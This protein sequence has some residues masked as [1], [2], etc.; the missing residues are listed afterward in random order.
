MYTP[1]VCK[2]IFYCHCCY[3][4]FPTNSIRISYFTGLF[5]FSPHKMFLSI[6][7]LDQCTLEL[8]SGTQCWC[9]NSPGAFRIYDSLLLWRRPTVI[10]LGSQFV[11]RAS[12][13]NILDWKMHPREKANWNTLRHENCA[14]QNQPLNTF[15]TV[16]Y[17]LLSIQ[18][19]KTKKNTSKQ[20]YIRDKHMG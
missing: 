9:F 14:G 10:A 6:I 3:S 16:R 19:H 11:A 15:F 13:I 4:L 18:T 12:R 8:T 5:C 1:S 17:A 20:K 7:L 2:N